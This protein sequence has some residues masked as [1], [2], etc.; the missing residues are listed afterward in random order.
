MFINWILVTIAS[1][2]S[3]CAF[4]VPQTIGQSSDPKGTIREFNNALATKDVRLLEPLFTNEP[5]YV[6]RAASKEALKKYSGRRVRNEPENDDA[7][8]ISP[9]VAVREGHALVAYVVPTD[10]FFSQKRTVTE[11]AKLQISGDEAVAKVRLGGYDSK[12]G[13]ELAPLNYDILLYREDGKWKIFKLLA[14]RR[15]DESR[16]LYNFFAKPDVAA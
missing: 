7:I 2:V 12:T 13:K 6:T 14:R 15:G 4:L 9:T 10:L 3:L 8:Q 1:T 16:Y 5:E 11:I